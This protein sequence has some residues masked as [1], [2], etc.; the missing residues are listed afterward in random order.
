MSSNASSIHSAVLAW[1]GEPDGDR[2]DFSCMIKWQQQL[3]SVVKQVFMVVY[4]HFGTSAELSVRH[5]GTGAEVCRQIDTDSAEEPATSAPICYRYSQESVL[6]CDDTI[7][8][9]RYTPVLAVANIRL[10]NKRRMKPFQPTTYNGRVATWHDRFFI[11]FAQP[12][13]SVVPPYVQNYR[14]GGFKSG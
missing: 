3:D 5:I 14:V 6:L 12:I 9:S 10:T 13:W 8:G 2:Q 1:Y 11:N 7:C 4:R